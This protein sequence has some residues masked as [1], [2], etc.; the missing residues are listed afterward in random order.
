MKI[1]RFGLALVTLLPALIALAGTTETVVFMRHAEKPADGLGQLS[2]Q[3]LNRA[4][5]LPKVL[6]SQFDPP[7]VILAPNPGIEKSDKGVLYNYIR[8]LATIEPTAIR[9]QMPVNTNFGIEQTTE[10]N[11]FLLSKDWQSKTAFVA[12]EH[13]LLRRAVVDL[14]TQTNG[15]PSVVPL[16]TGDDFDSLFVLKINWDSDTPKFGSFEVRHQ[17]LNGLPLTCPD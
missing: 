3:G 4:I 11:Q 5:A 2:C 9:L 16:W 10:L 13:H 7:A 14:I 12:W 8:P 15:D 6:L 17:K 1:F